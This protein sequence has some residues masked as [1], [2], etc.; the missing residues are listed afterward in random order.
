[1]SELLDNA[2]RPVLITIVY[3]L[4]YISYRKEIIPL[5]KRIDKFPSFLKNAIKD[6]IKGMRAD[7]SNPIHILLISFLSVFILDLILISVFKQPMRS[8]NEPIWFAFIIRGIFNPIY[9]EVL[10]RGFW[11]GIVA[12]MLIN[13]KRY[14]TQKG[15]EPSNVWFVPFLLLTSLLFMS[16]HHNWAIIPD[17]T[18]FLHGLL[19]GILYLFSDRNLA[20]PI[21]AHAINNL[22]IILSDIQ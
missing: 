11:L 6:A 19:Y 18:R 10:Y 16:A 2:I 7:F 3:V 12:F 9:E 1:M 15:E 20:M 5:R 4:L 17:T 14:L 22:L 21:T 8:Y 13:A